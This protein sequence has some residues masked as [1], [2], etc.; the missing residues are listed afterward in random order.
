MV[1]KPYFLNRTLV[2]I[3][4]TSPYNLINLLYFKYYLTLVAD[5]NIWKPLLA[6]ILLNLY[7]VH[8]S[9]GPIFSTILY[10]RSAG[11]GNNYGELSA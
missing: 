11:S 4:N 8:L 2:E 7:E 6:L 9:W 1:L 3:L 5:K 10:L